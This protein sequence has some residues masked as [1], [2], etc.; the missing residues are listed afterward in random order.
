MMAVFIVTDVRA[1][2]VCTNVYKSACKP[3][4]LSDGTGV[5]ATRPP[6]RRSE[7]D[8]L[9]SETLTALVQ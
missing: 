4:I 1:Q 6:E 3:G 8:P 7:T 5:V 2:Q 9:T